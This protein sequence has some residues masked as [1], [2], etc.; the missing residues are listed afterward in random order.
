MNRGLHGRSRPPLPDPRPA[1]VT[2]WHDE[3][4][5]IV[6]NALAT[7]L[8]AA[9]SYNL[10]VFQNTPA[11]GDTLEWTF[12]LPPGSYTL[13]VLG[14]TDLNRG[15]LDWYIDGVL[16]VSGQDWYTAASGHKTYKEAA[17]VVGPGQLH[18]LRGVINGKN[19]SSS[20][21]YMTLTK[22]SLR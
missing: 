1:Q 4:T 6:G 13:T 19:G 20:D 17:V 7:A 9:Y 2:L 3:A 14:T 11:N 18:T 16:V 8:N 5:V 21:Y 10:L 12:V 22:I 15:K